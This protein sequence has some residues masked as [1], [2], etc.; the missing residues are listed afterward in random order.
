M[1][2][3]AAKTSSTRTR[4]LE[5]GVRTVDLPRIWELRIRVSISPIGS[6]IS[7]PS[8]PARFHD[9]GQL[10]GRTQIAQ[11]DTGNLEFAVIRMRT[12]RK[13]AAVVQPGRRAV[14]RQLRKL[15]GGAEPLFHRL[16]FVTDDLFQRGAFL[17]ETIHQLL[18]LLFAL[19]HCFLSHKSSLPRLSC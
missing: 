14:A 11:R 4:I 8:S 18:A 6:F 2:P 7:L 1:Y 9:T 3:S 16:A 12:P 17:G 10:P 15:Q 13:L 19:D 5:A